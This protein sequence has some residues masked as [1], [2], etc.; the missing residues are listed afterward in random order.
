MLSVSGKLV[1][2]SKTWK[3]KLDKYLIMR[4]VWRLGIAR[5]EWEWI[6]YLTNKLNLCQFL[7]VQFAMIIINE[8]CED[9]KTTG[10]RVFPGKIM[11]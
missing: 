2:N 10:V 1:F 4:N 5:R 7:A 6:E 8:C 9:I 11:Y 3:C